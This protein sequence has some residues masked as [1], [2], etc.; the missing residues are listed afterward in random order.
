MH[1]IQVFWWK[2][3]Y[4]FL[5]NFRLNRFFWVSAK[6]L[7]LHRTPLEAKRYKYNSQCLSPSLMCIFVRS[8]KFRKDFWVSIWGKR[9]A[10]FRCYFHDRLRFKRGNK[11][12][13][14]T[15]TVILA[16]F[17]RF[18]THLLPSPWCNIDEWFTIGWRRHLAQERKWKAQ[19]LV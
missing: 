11:W 12:R 1:D 7:Y 16:Y 5:Y 17:P 14:T 19:L 18:R 2:Y 4:I 3:H 9:I 6:D 15:F 10:C 8:W 13:R